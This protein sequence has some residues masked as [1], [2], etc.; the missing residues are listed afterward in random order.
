MSGAKLVSS[1]LLLAGIA[2]CACGASMTLGTGTGKLGKVYRYYRCSSDARGTNLGASADEGERSCSRPR[3]AENDLDTLVLEQVRDQVLSHDR[4]IELLTRLRDREMLA[5]EQEN[6]LVPQLRARVNAAETAL[7]GLISIAKQVP[8]ISDQRPYQEQVSAVSVEL[9]AANQALSD[10]LRRTYDHAE[11]ITPE[12]VDLFRNDMLELLFGDN[13][14]VAK[15]YLS[16]IVAVV[17]VGKNH[18]DIQ[19]HISDLA[20]GID[21]A[22]ESLLEPSTPGVRTYERRWRKRCPLVYSI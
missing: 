17:I 5:R 6:V 10:L 13:R 14:A 11:G 22:K 15:I 2:R 8:S 16:T 7:N 20:V 18:I 1:P 21:R 4:L 9:R 12:S 3:V 19:G